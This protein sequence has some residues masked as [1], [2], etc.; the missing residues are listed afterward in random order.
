VS[1]H[2]PASADAIKQLL[3]AGNLEAAVAL[4][5]AL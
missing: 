1:K 2:G 4:A 5:W 3:A